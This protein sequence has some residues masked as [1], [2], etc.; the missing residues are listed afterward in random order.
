DGCRVRE[1]LVSVARYLHPRPHVRRCHRGDGHLKSPL[2]MDRITMGRLPIDVVDFAGALDAIE[3]MVTSSRGGCVFTP[4]VDHIVVAEDDDRFQRAY[5]GVS[6]SLVDGTPVVW[7]SRL[8]GRPLPEKVSGSDLVPP[9]M[10]LAARR[11]FRVFLL[12][13]S[14]GAAERAAARLV[15]K[16]PTLAIVGTDASRIDIDDRGPTRDAIVARVADARPDIV[17]VG[18]GAPK[19]ELWI[20][21][22]IERLRPAVLVAIGA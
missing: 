21:Q 2:G 11:G 8:L 13:G 5:A 19:Q 1:E 3:R 6:L 10:A 22:N 4:N 12:G 20:E 17:L 14:P 18:L 7:A 16:H 9:L 15:A